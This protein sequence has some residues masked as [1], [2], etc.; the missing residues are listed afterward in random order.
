[1]HLN[2]FRACVTQC[3]G[4]IAGIWLASWMGIGSL[5]G[6]EIG[7]LTTTGSCVVHGNAAGLLSGLK[8]PAT[9]PIEALMSRCG[10]RTADEV[11]KEWPVNP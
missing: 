8:V 4:L 3:F 1:M 7:R 10:W 11:H 5:I 6:V 2:P 9:V